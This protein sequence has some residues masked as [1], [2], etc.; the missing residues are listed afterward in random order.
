MDYNIKAENFALTDTLEHTQAVSSANWVHCLAL[1]V[2]TSTDIYLS[3]ILLKVILDAVNLREWISVLPEEYIYLTLFCLLVKSYYTS[4][5]F[6]EP[7]QSC[8]LSC[9][10]L[11]TCTNIRERINDWLTNWRSSGVTVQQGRLNQ[12]AH[13]ARAQDHRIF[14]SFWGAP[15][16]CGEIFFLTNYLITFAKIN[17]K[18]NPVNNILA[19]GPV[20][21]G[22]RAPMQVKMLLQLFSVITCA[23]LC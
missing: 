4:K 5:C 10:S 23:T 7:F 11:A 9:N 21:L 8:L 1:L 12:W 19:R 20:L 14:F 3:Q 2:H 18:G 17:F 13:W 6:I 22:P 15:T 16:G